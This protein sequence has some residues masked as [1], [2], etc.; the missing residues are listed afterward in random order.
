MKLTGAADH[1][2]E[3]R[4]QAGAVATACDGPHGLHWTVEQ[5]GRL[6]VVKRLAHA[7]NWS[8]DAKPM[9]PNRKASSRLGA[10]AQ[11][12]RANF[13]ATQFYPDCS[14]NNWNSAQELTDFLSQLRAEGFAGMCHKVSEGSY[15]QDPYWPACLQWCTENNFPLI[16]YHYVTTDNPSAQVATYTANHGTGHAMT[17]WEAN[18]G[19]VANLTAV[20]AAFNGAGITVALGYSP[21]WY[22]NEVGG[23]SLA[24]LA[25]GVV[26][27]AYPGGSGYASTIYDNAGGDNGEGWNSYADITPT[28]WQFTD[29][30]NIAGI[31]V[32]CNAFKGS[33]E[34]LAALFTGG[35]PAVTPTPPVTDPPA[36]PE[37]RD[38]A[39]QTAE[40]WG[41]LLTRWDFLAG[42]TAVEALGVIGEKLGIPGYSNPLNGASS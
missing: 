33:P 7:S 40:V 23:G 16:G 30:A 17:D 32:D 22:W 12:L 13:P 14:N 15:Y 19:N 3:I 34:E 27:S 11:Q 4:Y 24:G 9:R 8:W 35:T 10:A 20:V 21:E 2:G 18:G 1:A 36:V 6:H 26:S 29:S 31:D 42:N 28:C 41:Q 37:P 5:D 38:Q 25:T 39:T